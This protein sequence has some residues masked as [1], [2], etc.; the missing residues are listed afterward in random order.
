MYQSCI[1][2]VTTKS[3]PMKYM[4]TPRI[5]IGEFRKKLDNMMK[6]EGVDASKV[7]GDLRSDED[8][9]IGS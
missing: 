2:V 7:S 4:L 5:I 8:E 6:P 9:E 1:K 3:V